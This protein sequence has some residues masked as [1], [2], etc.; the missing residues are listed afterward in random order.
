M[1]CHEHEFDEIQDLQ[2]S[3]D[4]FTIA[5]N[6]AAE[7]LK[8]PQLTKKVRQ[9]V[10]NHV[11]ICKNIRLEYECYMNQYSNNALR[12]KIFYMHD[13]RINFVRS[14]MERMDEHLLTFGSGPPFSPKAI[15]HR[16]PMV[17]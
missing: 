3:V 9:E 13:Q 17:D 15:F 12:K 14:F 4:E 7:L 16:M 2:I 8:L 1:L 10:I 6:Y 11:G 5:E